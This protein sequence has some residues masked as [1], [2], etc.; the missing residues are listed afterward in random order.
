MAVIFPSFASNPTPLLQL[1]QG[2]IGFNARIFK[3]EVPGVPRAI[4]LVS[5]YSLLGYRDEYNLALLGQ[6]GESDG[7]HGRWG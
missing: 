3:S 6:Q 5:S 4:L 1:G 7:Y 2:W